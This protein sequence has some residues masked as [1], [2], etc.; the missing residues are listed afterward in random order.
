MKLNF[1]IIIAYILFS[2]TGNSQQES[3]FAISAY[4]PFLLNPAA[5]GMTNVLN[6][7]STTR[8][9]WTGYTGSP[10]T[11][12]LSGSAP[13]SFGGSQGMDEYNAFHEPF[14][15]A[16]SITSGVKKHV[17]GG[18]IINDAIGPF[19][20]TSLY[21]SYA[22]H[23]PLTKKISVGAGLGIGFSNFSINQDRVL[24]YHE[25][26]VTYNGFLANSSSQNYLDANAGIVA[27]SEQFV[28]GLSMQQAFNN[29]AVFADIITESRFN[30]H[31]FLTARYHFD[32]DMDIAVEPMATLKYEPKSP[33]SADLGARGIWQNKVWLGLQYRT[34]NAIIIQVGSVII[35]NLYLNYSYEASTGIVSNYASSSHE[36]QLGIYL[37]NNRNI[38]KEIEKGKE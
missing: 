19:M 33:I 36:I 16:P 13:I 24:L 18:R 1:Y 35:K 25:D 5:G 4:N 3:Q 9:Q 32:T 15:E 8:F 12:M 38:K 30:R 34:S 29:K 11:I 10:R 21:G 6:I 2:F 37:G 23:L 7:E 20:R 26:D 22:I 14:Y 17:V 27:Y 31:F 28:F